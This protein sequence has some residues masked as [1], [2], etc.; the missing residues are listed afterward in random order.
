MTR[1]LALT[2]S[3][4]FETL[5][6]PAARDTSHALHGAAEAGAQPCS[7]D[8][9]VSDRAPL[10]D[11]PDAF[12]PGLSVVADVLEHAAEARAGSSAGAYVSALGSAGGAVLHYVGDDR[13]APTAAGHALTSVAKTGADIAL[14]RL[15][16][17]PD[18]VETA[19]ALAAAVAP[20]GRARDVLEFATEANPV[21]VL[22][23]G[24]YA[25]V[26][27]TSVVV[28][29]SA[30]A[31]GYGS[32]HSLDHSIQT[33]ER[34]ASDGDYGAIPRALSAQSDALLELMTE[35]YQGGRA[36]DPGRM[37][38]DNGRNRGG[39]DWWVR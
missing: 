26:D 36:G 21:R 27:A 37:I 6:T 28:E 3:R 35:G 18:R 15:F 30:L 17:V 14:S 7:A 22:R 33:L 39:D 1:P 13:V 11:V 32:A 24:L 20:E 19:T 10:V 8:G 4:L 34:A 31:A 9:P 29:A 25:A 12:G 38:Y 2:Q 16:A 23:G 5:A